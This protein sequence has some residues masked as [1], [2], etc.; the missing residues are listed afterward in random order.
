M[1]DVLKTTSPPVKLEQKSGF[2][3]GML[4]AFGMRSLHPDWHMPTKRPQKRR[5]GHADYAENRQ[6][7]ADN[8]ERRRAGR[9]PEDVARQAIVQRM[10]NWNRTQWAR[11][12]YP[13]SLERVEHF[14]RLLR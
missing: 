5:Q 13:Q 10:N 12:G 4:A 2:I 7:A 11:A 14:R 9:D 3:E 8:R 1:K 6:N